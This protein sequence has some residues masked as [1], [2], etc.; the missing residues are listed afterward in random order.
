MDGRALT[1]APGRDP[2]QPEAEKGQRQV[3]TGRERPHASEV[4]S[5]GEETG[6]TARLSSGVGMGSEGVC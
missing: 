6:I 2:L 4:C 3:L 1:Y 5:T